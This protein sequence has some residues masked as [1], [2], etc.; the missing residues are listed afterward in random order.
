MAVLPLQLSTL[1]YKSS[2][3]YRTYLAYWLHLKYS[4][5]NHDCSEVAKLLVAGELDPLQQNEKY[6]W[7][8]KSLSLVG[9]GRMSA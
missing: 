3:W 6:H 9:Q 4:T 5:V 8:Q 2:S 7:A 1:M